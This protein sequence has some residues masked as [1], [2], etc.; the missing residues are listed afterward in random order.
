MSRYVP[1]QHGAWAFL[2]LPLVLGALVSPRSPLLLVL[3]I[4]WVAAYPWSYAAL[5]TVRSRRPGRFR[6]PLIVW[7]SIVLP[8]VL[9]LVV[10]RP[11]LVWVGAGYLAAFAVHLGYARRNDERALGNDLV[12]VAECSA[13]VVVTWA[14]A[15]GSR[16]WAPPAP[17]AVPTSVWVLSALCALVLVGSTLHVKS[18]L[19]ERD[20]PRY[21]RASVAFS[22]TGVPVSFGLAAW[23]GLPAG[24]WL[25]V[26]AVVM[27]VRAVVVPRLSWRPMRIGMTELVLVVVTALAAAAAVA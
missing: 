2:G 20:D 12:L 14:V 1:P 19:R 7:T 21:A 24:G 26:P 25:V 3:A 5:G 13:M 4:A 15:A 27:A 18:L 8:S 23:W 6:R 9:V 17:V 10:A 22:V 11:W 16:G